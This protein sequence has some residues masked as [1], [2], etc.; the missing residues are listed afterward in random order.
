MFSVEQFRAKRIVFFF[1]KIKLVLPHVK[2]GS[3]AVSGRSDSC[4]LLT[5]ESVLNIFKFVKTEHR[6]FLLPEKVLPCVL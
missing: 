2:L 5:K 6:D 3:R 1:N 4:R